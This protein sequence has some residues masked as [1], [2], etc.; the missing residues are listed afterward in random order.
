VSVPPLAR[1]LA[2]GVLLLILAGVLFTTTGRRKMRDFEVYWTAGTRAAAAAPLYRAEDEHYRFKYLPGFAVAVAPLSR[3]PLAPA[4]AF[5]MALSL[6]C[7]AAMV[8]VSVRV[9]GDSPL[10]S[11]AVTMFTVLA[12][13]K[14]FAHELVLGQA[15]LLFGALCVFG[16]GALV[17]NRELAA[18]ACFGAAALVK[19]YAVLFVPYL[20]LTRRWAAAA[21]AAAA[22]IAVLVLPVPIYGISSTLALNGQW[23]RT[24]TETSV[25]LLA[26]ADSISVFAMYAKWFGWGRAAAVLSIGTLAILGAAYAIVLARRRGVD[27]PEVL[28]VGLA[29]TLIPLATPQGWDYVL[30]LSTPLVALLIARAGRMPSADRVGFTI[31]LAVVALSLYDVM[32]RAAYARFMAL[33][34]I[35]VC[36]LAIV[37]VAVR[38]RVRRIA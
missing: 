7:L 35:T 22:T 28:E 6:F 17:R 37:A 5:W 1:R 4:K 13:A 3:L 21:A 11:R 27:A 33:S 16:L 2:G 34:I 20:L 25:P 10:G 36:Y 23:W 14:F 19:P 15:N 9:A 26:N 31:A 12:M 18:G 30:L 38:A 8:A 29:L 24:A 32:G